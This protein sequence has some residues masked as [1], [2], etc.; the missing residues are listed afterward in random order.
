M[1][2]KYLSLCFIIFGFSVYAFASGG[3]EE[4]A[5]PQVTSK[6]IVPGDPRLG[7]RFHSKTKL[8]PNEEIA[9][10]LPQLSQGVNPY[11]NYP[12]APK[13][14]LPNPGYKGMVLEDAL[15]KRRSIRS[16]D[17]FS[18]EALS[19]EELSQLLFAADGITGELKD[20]GINLRTA[21]SGG[22]LYPIEIYLAVNRVK[23]LE[24]GV[25]HYLVLGHSL[26][27]LRKGDIAKEAAFACAGQKEAEK[28][29]VTFIFTGIP[30]RSTQ[31]YDVRGWRYV[32]LETGYISQ[33][34]Y[35]EATS[36][37]LASTAMGA[38]YDDEISNFIGIDNR[39]EVPL[40][41]HAV[42]RPKLK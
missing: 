21:P 5:M 22:A 7:E 3:K 29:A 35:L 18:D 27:L 17:D 2:K 32:Y 14:K 11:K 40:H 38:F 19:L 6:K 16:E 39:K 26:E 23:G 10:A 12:D 33:N 34:I 36:L 15:R 28:A 25:Y 31:K 30:A 4:G 42:G 37:G 20:R 13:I 9:T 41:T 8:S 1:N 24:P